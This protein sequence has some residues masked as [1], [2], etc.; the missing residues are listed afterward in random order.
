[1]VWQQDVLH[2]EELDRDY[3]NQ[4]LIQVHSISN[5]AELTFFQYRIVHRLLM[6]NYRRSK[7]DREVS[8]LCVF[9]HNSVETVVHLLC[10]CEIVKPIWNFVRK[11]LSK[12]LRDTFE[13]SNAEIIFNDFRGSHKAFINSV[14]LYIKRY[15]YVSKCK[16]V[17]PQVSQIITT[18]IQN[19]DIEKLVALRSNTIVKHNRKWHTFSN[20]LS[21]N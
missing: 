4:I 21:G 18:L 14:I 8:P 7:W 16:N 20:W 2:G 11:W 15:I 10:D 13:L 12:L 19:R 17:K 5:Q 6:T 3:W 1:M 9:C